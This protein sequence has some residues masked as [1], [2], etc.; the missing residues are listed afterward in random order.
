MSLGLHV[1]LGEFAFRE[2][3][4]RQLYEVVDVGD[5]AAV[6]AEV[7]DQVERFRVLTGR[8]PS[9]IDSHQHV[10]LREPARTALAGAASRLSVPLRHFT[11]DVRYCG[12]F[13]GQ[14]E[15]GEPLPGFL[16]VEHLLGILTVLAPGVT[17]LACHPGSGNDLDTMYREERAQEVAVLSDPR[18]RETLARLRISLLSFQDLP[19]L[20]GAASSR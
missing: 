16:S 6:R 14:T 11:P 12:E 15:K 13:Y 10:H 4:W 9:H 5:A 20:R 17:E 3:S 2:G 19:R 8:D 7:E 1:D 18:V